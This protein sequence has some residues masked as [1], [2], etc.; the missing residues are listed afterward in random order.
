MQK[1]ISRENRERERLFV[2]VFGFHFPNAL[3][4]W[5]WAR[6]QPGAGSSIRVEYSAHHLSR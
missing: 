5:G 3:T 1:D 2:F 4:S 6:L